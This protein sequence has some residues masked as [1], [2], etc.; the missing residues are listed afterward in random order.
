M[1]SYT[2]TPS[3]SERERKFGWRMGDHGAVLAACFLMLICLDFLTLKMEAL[4][5]KHWWTS[6]GPYGVTSQKIMLFIVTAVRIPNATS[7]TSTYPTVW[8]LLGSYVASVW[9]TL[10]PS[11]PKRDGLSV[12]DTCILPR[13]CAQCF[14]E[15]GLG[16]C[17]NPIIHGMTAKGIVGSWHMNWDT[18]ES[19]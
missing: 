16:V 12:A 6:I 5:F 14:S 19:Q 4:F 11:S 17:N 9:C 2:V 1:L 3:R 10:S 18:K 13:V 8:H 7:L 15:A